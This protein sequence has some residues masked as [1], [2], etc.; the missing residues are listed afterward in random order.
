M[1]SVFSTPQA[2][3]PPNYA[4]MA[5]ASKQSA[6]LSYKL[7]QE[8]LDWARTTYKKDKRLANK[9][10]NAGLDRMR[11]ADEMALEDRA[12]YEEVYQPVEDAFVADAMSY[13]SPEDQAERAAQYELDR[14]QA[15]DAAA[16]EQ[17]MQMRMARATA[18]DR[19]EAFGI[20]PSQTRAGALDKAFAIQEA[21]ARAGSAYLAR[22]GEEAEYE[23][24]EKYH[25][26][27][28]RA[29]KSEAINIGKGYPGQVAQ[30]YN[31]AT[32]NG[33]SANSNNLASTQ[34][35]A[36]T[37]GTGTQWTAQG[38]GAMGT[39]G[40]IVN[41][42]YDNQ[43]AAAQ[44]NSQ[45]SSGFGQLLGWGTGMG[46]KMYGFEEGGAVP[47]DEMVGAPPYGVPV[48]TAAQPYHAGVPIT[49][50]MSPSR[51]VA[52][53]DVEARVNEGEFIIPEDVVSWLGESHFQKEIVKARQAKE[54]ET[55][56]RPTVTPALPV[57]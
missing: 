43:L 26:T 56:A 36:A 7:G 55:V 44:F 37:M 13:N 48:D 46:F 17:S 24:N 50:D 34:S 11:Q 27:V 39:A 25:D 54:Q 32:A 9:V 20:D 10:V 38:T 15:A 35:G 29:L 5:E 33:N 49:P 53:D 31:I 22:E 42:G 28:G 1:G 4:P 45:Q 47:D 6:R 14:E 57:G 21:T 12:R 51:G 3:P 23:A 52:I 30:A 8:Q 16:A 2:P 19:L 18:A 40:N 41:Q